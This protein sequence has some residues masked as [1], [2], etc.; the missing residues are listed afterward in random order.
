MN[1]LRRTILALVLGLVIVACGQDAPTPTASVDD[2]TPTPSASATAS[3]SVSPSPD[4]TATAAAD[5]PA[6]WRRIGVAEQGFSLAVPDGWQE[7]SPALLADSGAMDDL[8]E[9]NPDAVGALEQAQAAIEGGDIAIFAFDTDDEGLASGFASN[10]NAINV[11]P[12]DGSAEEAA[13]E[14][15]EAIRQQIPITGDVEAETAVLPAGD[16]A[17]L[18]YEWE[19]AD[20]EGAARS[21]SVAQYAIIGASGSG[22]ILS[23]SAA[24]DAFAEYEE[25]FVQIAESFRE[26]S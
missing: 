13:T 12:V 23:M 24:S 17:V 9:A 2:A 21:V 1:T 10:L 25:V 20:A 19:I 7:L 15:A 5:A 16:A 8:R 26:E 22:F 18:R 11:G 4:A 6:G 14:V 3:S